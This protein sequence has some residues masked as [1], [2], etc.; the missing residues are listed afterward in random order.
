MRA[1]GVTIAAALAATAIVSAVP[2]I[3]VTYPPPTASAR[4]SGERLVASWEWQSSVGG[5]YLLIEGYDGGFQLPGVKGKGTANQLVV[6]SWGG[7]SNSCA[8]SPSL[9]GWRLLR[10]VFTGA[11]AIPVYDAET[12]TV[13][14]A[15]PVVGERV[16]YDCAA[17]QETSSVPVFG[18]VTLDGTFT[19]KRCKGTE[20]AVCCFDG[21]ASLIEHTAG[22]DLDHGGGFDGLV[23]R[24]GFAGPWR[25]TVQWYV[26]G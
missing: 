24:E 18:T 21:T 9:N 26:T 2:A 7:W 16:V 23:I 19:L 17:R 6:V 15:I 8:E 3:A 10:S 22:G 20:R 13:Q 25:N 1:R 5:E 4:F 11:A 14:A 12:H